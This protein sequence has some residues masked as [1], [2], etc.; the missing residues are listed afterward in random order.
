MCSLSGGVLITYFFVVIGALFFVLTDLF[1]LFEYSSFL[2]IG[3]DS[4][5][6]L[7][8]SLE[9]PGPADFVEGVLWAAATPW[10]IL[11][12]WFLYIREQVGFVTS[13]GR[14]VAHRLAGYI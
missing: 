4:D 6:G 3:W 2:S 13:I 12:E 11:N 14:V 8:E 10:A 7:W 5:G 1:S 9:E